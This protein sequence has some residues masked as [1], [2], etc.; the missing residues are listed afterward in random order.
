VTLTPSTAQLPDSALRAADAERQAAATQLQ[1]H[2]TVGRLTWEELDERLGLAWAARTR[3]ELAVLFT[4][5]PAPIAPQIPEPRSRFRLRRDPRLLLMVVLAAALVVLT[6]GFVLV[7]VVAFI[8]IRGH[9]RSDRGHFAGGP[10]HHHHH[11]RGGP[12]SGNAAR[13]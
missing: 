7:P 4:D 6:R 11:R 9:R 8:L 3:G 5:L 13:R 10:H 1:D 2:F 12:A